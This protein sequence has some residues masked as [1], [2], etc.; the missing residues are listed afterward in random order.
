MGSVMAEGPQQA[1]PTGS[2][3]SS[4]RAPGS[5][6]ELFRSPDGNAFVD[7]Y[8]E[9]HRETYLLSSK[10]FRHRVA[11][12]LQQR[13]RK[14]P[15]AAELTRHIELLQAKAAQQETSVFEVYVRAACVADRIY[16]D[17]GDTSWSAIEI[18]AD[19]WRVVEN[20]PVRFIRTSAMLPLPMPQSG[21]SIELFKAL[22]NVRED[23]FVL[24][25]HWLLDA[26]AGRG[27]HPLLVL[28][29]PEG[30]AK[31]TLLELLRALIDPNCT[32]LGG[33]PRTERKLA[34]M[35]SQCH[36]QLFDNVSALSIQMSDALCRLS[37]GV[38]ARPVILNSIADVVT[39]PDLA[40]RC[41][42]ISCDS[43][44]DE[45]RRSSAQLWAEFEKAKAQILGLLLDGLSHGLRMLPDTKLDRSPRMADFAL[46]AAACE[47][48]FWPQGT[49]AASYG[50]HRTEAAEKLIG[51][52][53]VASAVRRLAAKR[54]EWIGT[55][56]E[57][58]NHLRALT[59][60]LDFTKAWPS[61]PPRLAT[62]VRELAPSLHKIGVDL[63]FIR[64]G[65]DRTRLITITRGHR[66]HGESR[67]PHRP[68]FSLGNWRP[69]RRIPARTNPNGPMIREVLDTRTVRTVRTVQ[70]DVSERR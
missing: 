65:H 31:S 52:D 1:P 39:R 11:L 28:I 24:L 62:R 60:N 3:S 34:E 70:T 49:F 23:E 50:A 37:T 7:I 25:V 5:T 54:P 63:N 67:R 6:V 32:P 8:V 57:L 36:L 58:D 13:A 18:R 47:G 4:L 69:R 55:A 53:P 45:R 20:P 27:H 12:D 29:G 51:A 17:L 10:G 16:V 2:T 59:G 68:Q 40:D 64:S 30:A 42:F 44:P 22:V 46:W 9:G 38:G 21:G 14:P 48:A 66:M 41:L 56:S 15:A 26:L 43:I 35:V 33:L 19:G 61:D